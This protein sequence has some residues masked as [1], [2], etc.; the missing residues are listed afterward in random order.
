MAESVEASSAASSGNLAE[1]SSSSRRRPAKGTGKL[2][3]ADEPLEYVALDALR[4]LPNE[5]AG[6]LMRSLQLS[7]RKV[8]QTELLVLELQCQLKE[9]GQR[10]AVKRSEP[11]AGTDAGTD[12]SPQSKPLSSEP[13]SVHTQSD[14]RQVELKKIR[15]AREGLHQYRSTCQAANITSLEKVVRVFRLAAED[16]VNEAMKEQDLKGKDISDLDE[17]DSPETILLQVHTH[18][19]FLWDSYK[20]ILDVLKSNN[21]LEEVYHETSKH[22]FE[23]CKVN[24]RPQEFKRLCDILRKNYQDLFKRTGSGPQNAVQPGNPDT[25]TKTLETRCRQMQ[26]A[27]ELDLW[28]EA[29]FTATEICE[30]MAKTRPKPPLRS[31]YYEYL[32][33]IF[34]KSENYLFH[35]FAS[36]K[37]V[38]YVKEL[39]LLASRSV[40]ATYASLFSAQ[41]VPSRDSISSQIIEKG[42]RNFASE[43]C[44]KLFDLVESDFTPLSLCQDAKPFLD[45]IATDDI[46]EGKLK[47][48]VTPLKQIIFF[49]LMKQL[50]E[51]YI[52]MT[53]EDFE[54][55]AS[56][57]PFNIAEKWMANARAQGI[58]IQI[59]YIQQA[60]VFGA[61][62]K[63]D[64]KSMRQPLIEIGFKL[65]QAMQRVAADELQKKDKLEKAHLLTNIRE[66]MDKET[67]T[68][69]QRKEE[70]ERRKEEFERKKQIQEK[71]ANEKLRK[72]EA[73]EAEQERLRQEVER[74][75]RAV[76]REEQKRKE[77]EIA[78]NKE[79]LEQMKKLADQKSN[80]K[81]AGKKITDIEE[82]DLDN[83]SFDQIE[84]AREA[85]ITRER[86]DKIRARKMENKRV[87]HLARALRE[88]ETPLIDDW[89]DEIEA[90]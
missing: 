65:Q 53:I 37:N 86:Q 40:L 5:A 52:S 58:S 26:V 27:T 41:S 90:S 28:R 61:P 12:D 4:D 13:L 67:K 18:F 81:V 84:K 38:M 59:N 21:R 48:Y 79:M 25:I 23:F 56:I 70:I 45:Q 88:E 6:R 75:R 76:D 80:L 78:K 2:H 63:L 39:E 85:Q 47:D 69:R 64:M 51:V 10:R 22:A 33:Q 66:R 54:R 19:R 60:I 24:S 73:A 30:L 46:C 1:P 62:R 89:A 50:S 57:V 43:P 15:V 42:L 14:A 7:S 16:K 20:V 82:E 3:I 72:Q 77:A 17:L 34:W 74:Q 31:M 71:E 87:D 44:K 29:Y 49:R 68:I 11:V 83:I 9:L 32:G 35:A 8:E 36:L 55:A